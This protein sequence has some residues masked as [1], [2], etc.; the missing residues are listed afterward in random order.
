MRR[1]T[2]LSA[3]TRHR[4]DDEAAEEEL[5]LVPAGEAPRPARGRHELRSLRVAKSHRSSVPRSGPT[6]T[7]RT[8]SAGFVDVER[9]RVQLRGVHLNAAEAVEARS[10]R[11]SVD[12]PAVGAHSTWLHGLIVCARA[13]AA[14]PRIGLAAGAAALRRLRRVD[15]VKPSGSVPE[16]NQE[17]PA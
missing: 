16:R 1:H 4:L 11:A 8:V 3:R 2:K 13:H 6:A 9:P 10:A 14:P 17:R 5:D 15:A 12:V 7:V